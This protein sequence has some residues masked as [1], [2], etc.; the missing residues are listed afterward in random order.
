MAFVVCDTT[1]EQLGMK[2]RFSRFLAS[3][4]DSL[5]L[6]RK[7][8]IARKEEGQKAPSQTEQKMTKALRR[9]EPLLP[10]VHAFT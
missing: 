3:A 4:L 10:C 1:A 2:C 7:R 8:G 6:C 5:R 9:C